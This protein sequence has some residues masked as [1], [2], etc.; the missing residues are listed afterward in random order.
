MSHKEIPEAALWACSSTAALPAVV[1]STC[2]RPAAA[3]A[4]SAAAEAAALPAAV[5]STG[6]RPAAAAAAAAV[7]ALAAVA[8]STATLDHP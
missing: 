2:T 3:V 8:A 5:A 6:T 1:A 4:G 7:A